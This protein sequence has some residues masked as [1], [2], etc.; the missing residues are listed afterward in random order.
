VEVPGATPDRV[1][2]S[3]IDATEHRGKSI[4]VSGGGN[5]ACEAALAL[6]DPELLN[7]VTLAH[8]GPVLKDVTTQ[9]SQAVDNAAREGRLQVIVNSTI[10]EIRP[11]KVLLHRSDGDQEIPNDVIFVM[12]GADLPTKFLRLIGVRLARKGG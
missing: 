11:G 9:N 2:Y 1:L 7:Q 12:I 4:L 10:G 3:L 5:A 8:R 6:A